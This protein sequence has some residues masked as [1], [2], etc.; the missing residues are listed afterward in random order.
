M[1]AVALKITLIG[2][3]DAQLE[4]LVRGL[5]D[6]VTVAPPEGLTSLADPAA[7]QPDFVVLDIRDAGVVPPALAVLKRQHP[8]T[9]VVLVAKALD[10]SMMLAALRS[11]ANECLAEPV[12]AA[13]LEAAISRIA[14]QQVKPA[15]NRTFAFIGAKGGVGTTSTAVNVATT[16]AKA[17]ASGALLVDLNVPQGDAGLYLGAEPRFSVVDALENI[18]RL[19]EALF[20]TLV[21][22][23]TSRL[24]LLAAPGSGALARLAS[25]RVRALLDF[26]ATQ[27]EYTIVDA[28]RTDPAVLDALDR[29][30]TIVVVTTQELP[31]VRSAASLAKRLQQRYGKDKVKVVM[32][33]FDRQAE[34]GAEDVEQALGS[35]LAYQFPSDYRLTVAS[36][37]KGRPL[38]LEN[39]SAL[40]ASF[41]KFARSLA[42]VKPETDEK[43]KDKDAQSG[44]LSRITGVKRA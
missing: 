19:D 36:L 31:S 39:H 4:Q 41:E 6:T 34:I 30:Q 35:P 13:D 42:G 38:V 25:D 12:A 8:T 28:P 37:N 32:S 14:A 33:R 24:D 7:S 26:T 17:S 40:A 20:R 3:R 11:G 21:V 27:F 5:A 9:A 22:R 1:G 43:K 44:W 29:A 16:L 23:T 2:S 15:T 18:H 10:A